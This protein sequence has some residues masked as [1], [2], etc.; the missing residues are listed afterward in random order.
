VIKHRRLKN[1][2]VVVSTFGM[3]GWFTAR[4]LYIHGRNADAIAFTS[5]HL[6]CGPLVQMDTKAIRPCNI[7]VVMKK[8]EGQ[9]E[10]EIDARLFYLEKDGTPIGIA[11]NR[12]R[13]LS[14]PIGNSFDDCWRKRVRCE[15]VDQ[16]AGGT[17]VDLNISYPF[18]QH[19]PRRWQ[20]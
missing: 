5:E 9:K 15:L 18:V 13:E 10:T 8:K 16:R 6:A 11:W 20:P 4:E 7:Y 12:D 19:Y 14:W 3:L 1:A 2:V 17:W